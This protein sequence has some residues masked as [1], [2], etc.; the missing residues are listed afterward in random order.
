MYSCILASVTLSWLRRSRNGNWNYPDSILTV[1]QNEV[2]R[3]DRMIR[4][5]WPHAPGVYNSQGKKPCTGRPPL[6]YRKSDLGNY[7]PRIRDF[8]REDSLWKVRFWNMKLRVFIHDLDETG[9]SKIKSVDKAMIGSSNKRQN[10][11][12][13]MISTNWNAGFQLTKW[14]LTAAD[15]KLHLDCRN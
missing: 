13:K 15:G 10:K 12:S 8:K 2:T 3:Y 11:D 14:N 5:K 1:I 6:D 7:D 9:V 4:W